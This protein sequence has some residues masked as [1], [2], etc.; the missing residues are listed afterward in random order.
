MT[1]WYNMHLVN[2]G[3][4][5]FNSK[6]DLDSYIKG[7]CRFINFGSKGS[8]YLDR[9]SK[10]VI[11]LFD[12]A[13]SEEEYRHFEYRDL[14]F[15]RFSDSLNSTY[16]FPF[17]TI[18]LEGR[19]VGYLAHAARGKSLYKI[20]PLTVDLDSLLSAYLIAINDIR[21]ISKNGILSDDLPYN[22][23]FSKSNGR[24]YMVDTDD[25]HIVD[26][27]EDEIYEDNLRQL[28]YTVKTFLVDGYFD[29]FIKNYPELITLYKEAD[30]LTFLK[31]YRNKLSEV[32]GKRITTLGE[33]NE[34]QDE[35]H[36]REYIRVL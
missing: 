10:S 7:N 14:D 32:V 1:L 3:Y 17:E 35:E 6:R 19:D 5:I 16:L 25:Y 9:N 12:M 22:T 36:W 15:L 33:A 24:L 29:D 26:D 11:K 8:A 31:A 18:S 20:D 4:M 2:G 34:Y 23:L 27:D 28:S 13:L 21:K 30:F